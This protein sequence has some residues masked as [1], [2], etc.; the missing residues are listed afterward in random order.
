MAQIKG[1]FDRLGNSYVHVCALS[2]QPSNRIRVFM[3]YSL[4]YKA[5]YTSNQ[6]TERKN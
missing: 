2:N 4:L 5:L 1:L 6:N 3:K